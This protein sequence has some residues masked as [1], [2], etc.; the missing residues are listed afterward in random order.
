MSINVHRAQDFSP[1]PQAPP[2]KLS[3]ESG[4]DRD[5]R[6]SRRGARQARAL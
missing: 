1:L 2:L 6:R 5:S 4:G 3:G